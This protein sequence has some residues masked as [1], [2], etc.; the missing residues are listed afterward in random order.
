MPNFD[1]SKQSRES[2]SYSFGSLQ[3]KPKPEK[4][5]PAAT[6][7]SARKIK[8]LSSTGEKIEKVALDAATIGRKAGRKY[9]NR[10]EGDGIKIEA[11]TIGRGEKKRSSGRF[12]RKGS[13]RDRKD[14]SKYRWSPE[15]RK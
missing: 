7:G 14:K 2:S 15:E 10:D 4:P 13:I 5:V 11:G 9:E 8:R 12:V 3:R 1:S 6:P